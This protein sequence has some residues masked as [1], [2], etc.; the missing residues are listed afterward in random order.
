[1]ELSS[2]EYFAPLAIEKMKMLQLPTVNKMDND[3]KWN[4]PK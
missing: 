3:P 2:N 4:V 1:M